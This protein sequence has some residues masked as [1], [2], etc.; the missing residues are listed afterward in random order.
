M[1]DLDEDSNSFG[2]SH[3]LSSGHSPGS[4]HPPGSGHF[5]DSVYDRI[6][7]LEVDAAL[8]SGPPILP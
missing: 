6:D 3:F 2:S 7:K 5:H 1:F 4:G 8:H